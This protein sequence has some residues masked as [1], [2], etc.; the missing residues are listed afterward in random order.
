MVTSGWHGQTPPE[1]RSNKEIFPINRD[2]DVRF[3]I[4]LKMQDRFSGRPLDSVGN[5]RTR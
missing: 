2:K 4:L 3:G 5:N 1:A